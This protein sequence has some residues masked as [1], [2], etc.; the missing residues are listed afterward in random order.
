MINVYLI[1]S[2]H[3]PDPKRPRPETV[4]LQQHHQLIPLKFHQSALLITTL[5]V[6]HLT[7]PSVQEA[8]LTVVIFR[9]KGKLSRKFHRKCA[10]LDVRLYVGGHLRN[11]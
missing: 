8:I 9:C 4:D 6:Q 3:S 2:G 11:N 7:P 5:S 10:S 1:W